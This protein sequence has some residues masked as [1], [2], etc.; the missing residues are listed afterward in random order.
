MNGY[1][2]MWKY[3]GS[4][5][6]VSQFC[7]IQD[8]DPDEEMQPLVERKEPEAPR[9]RSILKKPKKYM[10]RVPDSV[11]SKDILKFLSTI[12]APE[13][14]RISKRFNSLTNNLPLPSTEDALRAFE[15]SLG[16]GQGTFYDDPRKLYLVPSDNLHPLWRDFL[17][18]IGG[19]SDPEELQRIRGVAYSFL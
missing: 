10:D 19:V 8:P 11:L 14:I 9:P 12:D 13:I 16:L 4:G 6:C 7:P 1:R 17:R 15:K 5:A 3:R 18:G 2:G